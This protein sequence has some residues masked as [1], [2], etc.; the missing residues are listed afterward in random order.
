MKRIA[1]LFVAATLGLSAPAG[2]SAQGLLRDLLAQ[3]DRGDRDNRRP[4]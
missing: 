4:P 1:L 3:N 2:A